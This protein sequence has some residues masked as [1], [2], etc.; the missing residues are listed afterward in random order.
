MERQD[1]GPEGVDGV[2]RVGERGKAEEKDGERSGESCA[3]AGELDIA[4]RD[5][6]VGWVEKRLGRRD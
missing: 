6:V 2:S 1:A 5:E 3:S 4:R